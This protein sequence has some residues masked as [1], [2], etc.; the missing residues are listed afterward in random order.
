MLHDS[1][2]EHIL[3]VFDK[4]VSKKCSECSECKRIRKK[5][6]AMQAAS[7]A[8]DKSYYGES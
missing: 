6:K 1:E 2:L 8:Y 5:L 7:E 4:L 3:W